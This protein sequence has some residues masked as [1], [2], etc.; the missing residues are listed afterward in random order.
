MKKVWLV[1]D[2]DGSELITSEAPK[3][4]I[5]YCIHGST[6]ETVL[7][8]K[9][10][11]TFDKLTHSEK[12]IYLLQDLKDRPFADD[13]ITEEAKEKLISGNIYRLG[14]LSYKSNRFLRPIVLPKGSIEKFVGKKLSFGEEPYLLEERNT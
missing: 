2:K 5:E 3:V 1:V 4:C 13:N 14:E 10:A 12:I 8:D 7:E 9:E 11:Y 6:K